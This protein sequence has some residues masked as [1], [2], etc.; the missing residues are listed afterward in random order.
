M[1]PELL[2]AW[3]KAHNLTQVDAASWVGVNERTYQ[4]WEL[5]ESKIPHWL[6]KIINT[7]GEAPA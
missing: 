4:R 2:R 7:F 6:P 5:G 3:R 1:S